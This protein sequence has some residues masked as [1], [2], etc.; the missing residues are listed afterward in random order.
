MGVDLTNILFAQW[1]CEDHFL[2]PLFASQKKN[3][4]KIK[5]SISCWAAPSV[6]N[7]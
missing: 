4:L 1:N 7:F 3:D 6:A 5:S 2:A